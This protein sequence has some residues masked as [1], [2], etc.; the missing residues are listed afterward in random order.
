[1]D[2][3][4]RDQTLFKLGLFLIVGNEEYCN[5][6]GSNCQKKKGCGHWKGQKSNYQSDF[7]NLNDV[8]KC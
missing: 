5:K 6:M 3:N 2:Q 1:M 8:L 7:Q 4:L